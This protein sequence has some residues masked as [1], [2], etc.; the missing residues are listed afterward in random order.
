[1]Y[2]LK[3]SKIYFTF[4][5]LGLIIISACKKLTT[6]VDEKEQY[7]EYFPLA[8][9]NEYIYQV[10]SYFYN[11]FDEKYDTVRYQIR[12][13]IDSSFKDNI[14]ETAFRVIH[15]TRN[16]PNEAWGNIRIY[17][18]KK[19]KD[20]VEQVIENI[21]YIPM[22]FPVEKDRF[23]KGN[24][25]NTLDSELVY[26]YHYVNLHQPFQYD[27]FNFAKTVTVEHVNVISFLDNKYAD[28]VFSFGVGL[29]SKTVLDTFF[30]GLKNGV[31]VTRGGIKYQKLVSYKVK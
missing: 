5:L 16:N 14:N 27:T 25:L 17:Y 30:V 15:E 6:T 24:A 12:E 28:E 31:K 9:G 7:T 26:N 1:M 13:T 4:I 20:R 22:V 19:R 21:R 23:W 18:W 10:D 8:S 3:S 29:V 11:S 2:K